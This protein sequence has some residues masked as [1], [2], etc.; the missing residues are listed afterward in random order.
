[1]IIDNDA[2]GDSRFSNPLYILKIVALNTRDLGNY[3]LERG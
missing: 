3:P 1:L 2:V